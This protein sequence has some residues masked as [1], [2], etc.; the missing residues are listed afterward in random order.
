MDNLWT[1][2]TN[3]KLSLSTPA[4]PP[5]TTA[6]HN[7]HPTRN[8]TPGKRFGG[9]TSSHGKSNPF[10]AVPLAS[11][12]VSPPTAGA[13]SAFGLGSGAFAS[14]GAS[15]KTPKTPGSALDFGNAVSG[16]PTPSGEKGPA[17]PGLTRSGQNASSASLTEAKH[18]QA[19][20]HT[21][22]HG[23]V[24]WFRPPVQKSNGYLEYE[25]TLHAMAAFDTVEDFFAIYKHLKRPSTLPLVSD[26]HIF[27][28]GIRPV[29]EDEE[30]K[31]GGKWIVRLKKGVADRYWEDLLFAII[32]DQ[33][34]EASEEVCGAVLS[35]RNGEDILS[36]WTRNDGGRVLKVRETMKRVLAFPPETKVEWKS[37]DSSIAQRTAIDDARKDKSNNQH[38]SDRRNGAKDDERAERKQA[39]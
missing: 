38:S 33:F 29:W 15:A 37:H 3:S 2:R 20:A 34:G 16:T 31:K 23:W 11:P 10:N 17:E 4:A 28:N 36:I 24:F 6:S 8:Y 22:K 13:S 19:S 9:D 39:S 12:A 25:K 32:G 18:P 27:K 1:R 30:N 14:F 7:D 21:L 5:A 35:V 26:Y